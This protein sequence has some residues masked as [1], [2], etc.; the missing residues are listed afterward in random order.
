[1]V[2]GATCSCR[3]E[4][5]TP[6]L[7]TKIMSLILR[8]YGLR[9]HNYPP[10]DVFLPPQVRTANPLNASACSLR[11]Y[12]THLHK[13]AKRQVWQSCEDARADT[14]KNSMK[15]QNR[16][17]LIILQFEQKKHVLESHD[18]TC[19]KQVLESSRCRSSSILPFGS[20]KHFQNIHVNHPLASRY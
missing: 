1:M 12:R 3:L 20:T 13:E 15:Q 14:C 8:A 5:E 4:P 11:K 6:N 19:V 9:F 10:F 18:V 7:P 2:L 17:S 16:F